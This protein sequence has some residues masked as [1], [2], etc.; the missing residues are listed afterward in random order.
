MSPTR[1]VDLHA[2]WLLQYAGET[3]VYDPALYPGVASR[4]GQSEG[5]LQATSAAIVS[6]FR[7]ETDWSAQPD[8]WAALDAL[9]TRIEAEFPGRV[10]RD[11]IDIDRWLDDPE[12]LAWAM[13]GVEGF[14][15]LIRDEADLDR[16][17]GL[18]RRGVRLFQPTYTADSLLVGS[19]ASGDDRGL[20]DLGRRFL[21]RLAEIADPDRGP[22]PIVDLA[23]LNPTAA[24]DVL[25]WL[26][27]DPA[28]TRRLIPVYSH[29]ALRHDDFTSPRAITLDNL[30]R[31]RSF[32]GVIGFGVSPPFYSNPDQIRSG[33]EAAAALPFLGRPGFEGIAIGTD[34]L[35]VDATLPTLAN[36]EAV[37]SWVEATFPAEAARVILVEN[38][39]RLIARSISATDPR[40]SP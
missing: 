19:S 9:I 38:G 35:G 23:H 12:G 26:E 28:R 40:Q 29:G 1:I 3:T 37:A 14:D 5:Y 8:P 11:P 16:L 2:D 18:L 13:I 15:S 21:E 39:R 30:A 17:P 10:L 33:I 4:L 6:C 25:S 36:A 20:L 22:R 27:S 7:R 24:A 32:G 31:L 34:F